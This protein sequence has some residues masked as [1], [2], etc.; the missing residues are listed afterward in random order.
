VIVH[1]L[2]MKMRDL[3]KKSARSSASSDAINPMSPLEISETRDCNQ[4]SLGV[5]TRAPR[6]RAFMLLFH[7]VIDGFQARHRD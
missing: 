3:T 4:E 2:S 1:I 7:T 5:M 6:E